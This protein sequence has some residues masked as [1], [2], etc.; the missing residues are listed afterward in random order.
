MIDLADL[1]YSFCESA[2][3]FNL[4]MTCSRVKFH[5]TCEDISN[6]AIKKGYLVRILKY[7]YSEAANRLK[8]IQRNLLIEYVSTKPVEQ[9][10]DKQN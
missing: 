5:L 2:T 3:L 8:C 1:I 7:K 10:E 9:N 4:S 6:R